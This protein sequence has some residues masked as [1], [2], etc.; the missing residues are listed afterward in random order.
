MAD[1]EK[2]APSYHTDTPERQNSVELA[3]PQGWRYRHKKVGRF[4]LPWYSSPETQIT[5]VA[6]VCFLCPGEHRFRSRCQTS[7]G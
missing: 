6:F 4:T 2:S 7:I 3:L 5:L 1:E